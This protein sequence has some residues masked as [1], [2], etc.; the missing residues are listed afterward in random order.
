MQIRLHDDGEQ[1]LVD[2]AS[3]LEQ[4]GEERPG[5]QLGDAQ[6]QIPAVVASTR[7]RWPL[8]WADRSGVRWLGAAPITAVSSASINAW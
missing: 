1:G 4:A 3:P 6:L 8:R 5:S 2:A 7:G